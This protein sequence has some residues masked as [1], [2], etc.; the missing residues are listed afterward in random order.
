MENEAACSSDVDMASQDKDFFASSPTK[1]KSS[2]FSPNSSPPQAQ[3]ERD[4]FSPTPRGK[5]ESGKYASKG[6][7]K[8]NRERI[9]REREEDSEEEE[10]EERK[11]VKPKISRDRD[12]PLFFSD[13]NDIDVEDD[14]NGSIGNQ[15]QDS[16]SEDVK[17][18]V[19]KA[20]SSSKRLRST[21]AAA[22]SSAS[23]LNHQQEQEDPE[24]DTW[25]SRYLGSFIL[26]AYTA[27]KKCETGLLVKFDDIDKSQVSSSSSGKKKKK[28][29]ED[30][31]VRMSAIKGG[32][33]R[34]IENTRDEG[35]ASKWEREKDGQIERVTIGDRVV[36]SRFNYFECPTD[37][38]FH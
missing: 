35:Q 33:F 31:I 30:N 29:P 26:E 37:L 32:E 18:D 19:S 9:K 7:G 10:E 16:E 14:D 25:E 38:D 34:R 36:T 24:L 5:L 28:V 13:G 21:S 4:S 22:A 1:V 20:Q 6:K 11:D 8:E 3:H 12:G 23:N 2:P 27:N 15:D 17:P